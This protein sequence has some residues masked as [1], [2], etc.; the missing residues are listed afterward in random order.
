ML[1]RQTY[2]AHSDT[3]TAG[4][5]LA[6]KNVAGVPAIKLSLA[7]SQNI[8]RNNDVGIEFRFSY[9]FAKLAFDI[10]QRLAG[11]IDS[12]KCVALFAKLR[13]TFHSL[14]LIGIDLRSRRALL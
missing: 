4:N 11:A 6:S 10:F 13:R 12:L 14:L 8:A 3:Q 7:V 2:I 9:P 5:R 1:F